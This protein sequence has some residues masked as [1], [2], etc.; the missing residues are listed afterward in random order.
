LIPTKVLNLGH[1]T[2]V[3]ALFAYL[4]HSNIHLQPFY[5]YYSIKAFQRGLIPHL[6]EHIVIGT[7]K[8]FL[9]PPIQS[10]VR[11]FEPVGTRDPNVPHWFAVSSHWLWSVSPILI[12]QNVVMILTYPFIMMNTIASVPDV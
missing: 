2:Y 12:I 9:I 6:L 5:A 4:T 8:A 7:A 11:K 1:Y 3:G 10:F